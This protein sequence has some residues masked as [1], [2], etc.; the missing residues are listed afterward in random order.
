MTSGIVRFYR[1]VSSGQRPNLSAEPVLWQLVRLFATHEDP[2]LK[3]KVG[4]LVRSLVEYQPDFHRLL[5]TRRNALEKA[6]QGNHH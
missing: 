6:I 1:L 5:T 4:R 3:T 2:T